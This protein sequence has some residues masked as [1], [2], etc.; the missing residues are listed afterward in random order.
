M[1]NGTNYMFWKKDEKY[2][3]SL[4]VDVWDAIE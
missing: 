4:S 1:F 2:I 3:Q